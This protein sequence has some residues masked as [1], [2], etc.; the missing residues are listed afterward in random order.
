MGTSP[1]VSKTCILTSGLWLRLQ[2]G[3]RADQACYIALKLLYHFSNT[4]HNLFSIL[5]VSAPEET[6]LC[7]KVVRLAPFKERPAIESLE[8]PSRRY[9]WCLQLLFPWVV[10]NKSSSL[11]QRQC[12]GQSLLH[13]PH[14]LTASPR[15]MWRL[16]CPPERALVPAGWAQSFSQ[17]CPQHAALNISP[18]AFTRDRFAYFSVPLKTV[19]VKCHFRPCVG[20]LFRRT[21]NEQRGRKTSKPD[22]SQAV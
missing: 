5:C 16:T 18:P 19:N 6:I 7:W 11:S 1:E 4:A 21:G 22:G 12:Q 9:Y 17:H 14:L 8:N 3:L 15:W 2:A 13:S 10:S 20:N